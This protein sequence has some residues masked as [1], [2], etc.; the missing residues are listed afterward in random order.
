MHYLVKIKFLIADAYQG[1]WFKLQTHEAVPLKLD[2]RN[3][4]LNRKIAPKIIDAVEFDLQL[5][6]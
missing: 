3:Y 6:A 1:S 2:Y 4:M 5:K